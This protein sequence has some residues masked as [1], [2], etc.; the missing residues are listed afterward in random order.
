MYN[1]LAR[2]DN[3]RMILWCYF[4]WYLCIVEQHFISSERLWLNSVGISL[5]VGFA[6]FISTG[7]CSLVRFKDN[8]WP[9]CRL[10]ICPFL[11]SSFSATVKGKGF[12]L[13]FSP[14]ANENLFASGC[15]LIFVSATLYCRQHFARA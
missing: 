4:I 6:L 8:F 2:L 13:L 10:F 12:I 1:Y 3:S 7:A 11:V 9:S 15:C 14:L 5:L